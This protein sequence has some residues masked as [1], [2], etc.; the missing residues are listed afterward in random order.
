MRFGEAARRLAGQAGVLLGWRPDA[1][2]R[3]TPAE[4]AAVLEALA[5]EEAAP[6]ERAELAA[7]MAMF[8]DEGEAPPPPFRRSPSPA[9]AGED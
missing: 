8:P 7:L 2:W 6:L 4:L 1:F 3:A 5:G 9:S